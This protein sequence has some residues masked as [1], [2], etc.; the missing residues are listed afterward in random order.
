MNC[1]CKAPSPALLPILQNHC[2]SLTCIWQ[3]LVRI[4]SATTY[5]P[6]SSRFAPISRLQKAKDG[7]AVSCE[8]SSDP[9]QETLLT[10]PSARFGK[11]IHG[12]LCRFPKT[13]WEH[14]CTTTPLICHSLTS[15]S[16]STIAT[17]TWKRLS[18]CPGLYCKAALASVS[19]T[20]CCTYVFSSPSW[21]RCFTPSSLRLGSHTATSHG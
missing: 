17:L 13:C 6:P 18:L 7:L 10:G 15:L 20:V 5:F 19:E 3:N 1:E 9:E 12:L 11:T 14:S 8:S 21:Q 16:P 4:V 2:V